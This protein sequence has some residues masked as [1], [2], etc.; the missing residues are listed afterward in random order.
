MRVWIS[1]GSNIDPETNI[2][3]AFAALERLGS[4]PARS[5]VYRSAPHGG[6][7]GPDFLNAV[8]LLETEVEDLRAELRRIE[9]ELGRVRPA[10]PN[11]PRPIDLDVLWE[12]GAPPD[13]AQ[14]ALP[15]VVVP[16][17]DVAPDL[18]DPATGKTVR[19]L[20]RG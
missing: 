13:P 2:P 16:L 4:L 19:D 15:Y 6:A 11:A 9:E 17:A 14:L 1:L 3:A 12:A 20:A 18:R 10:P 8:V 7:Q 5:G